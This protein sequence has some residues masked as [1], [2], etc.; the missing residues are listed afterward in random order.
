MVR[1]LPDNMHH[2]KKQRTSISSAHHQRLWHELGL[3]V[4][5]F[6][7]VGWIGSTNVCITSGQFSWA[8]SGRLESVQKVSSGCHRSWIALICWCYARHLACHFDN[9]SKAFIIPYSASTR[10]KSSIGFV[11][12][13]YMNLS[14]KFL[15]EWN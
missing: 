13:I 12:T 8:R 14:T 1:P 7:F 3:Y 4:R 15:T 9:E 5:P 2:Y 10:G 11:D 6:T